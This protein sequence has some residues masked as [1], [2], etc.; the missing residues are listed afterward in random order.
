MS[1]DIK[2]ATAPTQ[3]FIA[4]GSLET[5]EFGEGQHM[6]NGATALA[7]KITSNANKHIE[8]KFKII[9]GAKT[10]HRI[11]NNSDSRVGLDLW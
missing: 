6:V 5:P 7:E 3:V 11:S 10:R 1:V 8:V 9:D 2:H 4:V